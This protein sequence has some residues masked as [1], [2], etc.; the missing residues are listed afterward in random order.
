VKPLEDKLSHDAYELARDDL[1]P[2][3]Q[4]ARDIG[5]WCVRTPSE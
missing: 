1:L 5:L 2:L 3:Q 4:K